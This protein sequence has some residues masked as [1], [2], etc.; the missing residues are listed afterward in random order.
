MRTIDVGA[1]FLVYNVIVGVL[2]ML[3]SEKLGVYAG[4]LN[5]SRR[6]K[7]ARLTRVS[8]LAFGACVASLSGFIYV[9]F[10]MLKIGI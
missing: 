4:Y 5:K 9:A 6:E 8:T 7:I 10:H 3:S 1:Y 2:V